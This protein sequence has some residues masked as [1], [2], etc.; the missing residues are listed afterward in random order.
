MVSTDLAS[1][2]A[3]KTVQNAPLLQNTL[4]ARQSPTMPLP[5]P[6]GGSCL[7]ARGPSALNKMPRRQNPWVR[8]SFPSGAEITAVP[9][10]ESI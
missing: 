1:F 10:L 9:S 4:S 3:P 5:S 7:L 6:P 8:S 2:H